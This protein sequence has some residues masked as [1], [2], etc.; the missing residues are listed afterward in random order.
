MN[1]IIALRG[2]RNV[3]KSTT[4]RL[5]HALLLQ[6][7]FQLINSSFNPH[8]GDFRS[9]FSKNGKMIGITSSGDNFDL[10]FENLNALVM[11]GCTI[12]ACACRTYDR[13]GLGTN[14]AIDSFLNYQKQ[15]IDK[16]I[17]GSVAQQNI[18]NNADAQVLLATIES[19]I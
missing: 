11:A 7:G 8:H 1:K 18:A 16:T 9:V 5:F 14:F 13:S 10:V 4:I 12:C 6:N 2:K 17:A 19:L 3:G 15:Y